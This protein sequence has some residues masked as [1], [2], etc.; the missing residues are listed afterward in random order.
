LGNNLLIIIS[1]LP[2]TGKTILSK[3]IGEEFRL[4]VF[5]VDEM[6]ETMWDVIGHDFDFEF[7]DKIGRTNFE[8]LFY[9]I[10]SMLSKGKSLVVEAHFN[11]EMN[12][13]RIDELKEK[14]SAKL[15]Q[16]HCYCESKTLQKR[17]SERMERDGYHLGHKHVIN[18]Y[19]KDRVLNS[20]NNNNKRL[21]INGE[22]YDLDTTNPESIDYEKLFYFIKSNNK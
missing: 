19:G 6:K 9:C 8:L 14:Y 22:T 7:S 17:F 18:L 3:K 10:H 12:N 15:L 2:G 13:K 1:G 16:V 21:E 4:P 20:L 11:P 5:S